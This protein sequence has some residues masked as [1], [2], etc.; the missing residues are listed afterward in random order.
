M[1]KKFTVAVTLTPVA[2]STLVFDHAATFA[3][4]HG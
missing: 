2:I 4:F 1:P 3:D